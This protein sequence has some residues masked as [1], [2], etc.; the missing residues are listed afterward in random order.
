MMNI[1]NNYDWEQ[2]YGNEHIMQHQ[3]ENESLS[4][5]GNNSNDENNRCGESA[6][7]D[8]WPHA[9]ELSQTLPPR[10]HSFMNN[11]ANLESLQSY[12]DTADTGAQVTQS[13]EWDCE[14]LKEVQSSAKRLKTHVNE[15]PHDRLMHTSSHVLHTTLDSGQVA[16]NESAT[17]SATIRPLI[18][19]M[20]HPQLNYS[21]HTRSRTTFEPHPHQLQH[22]AYEGFNDYPVL[23]NHSPRYLGVNS[24][25]PHQQSHHRLLFRN[26]TNR[27]HH[28][29]PK[30]TKGSAS[31]V[32]QA[33]QQ[34]SSSNRYARQKQPQSPEFSTLESY[35]SYHHDFFSNK[36][37]CLD[38]ATDIPYSHD[39]HQ[40]EPLVRFDFPPPT[41]SQ[42]QQFS[43]QIE[44]S[45][46]AVQKRDTVSKTIAKSL[47]LQYSD[48]IRYQVCLFIVCYISTS[49][50]IL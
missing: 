47:P 15:M 11:T 18:H 1:Q 10:E 2:S 8:L 35:Y 14:M 44:T 7:T 24:N 42:L 39:M 46:S 31:F 19:N 4:E 9:T 38:G 50:C 36:Q 43:H 5:D 34:A 17:T 37:V 20:P 26:Y 22:A 48:N 23:S 27:H 28:Q 30:Q 33:H 16:Q 40:H 3:D 45:M 32:P 13:R 25:W 49:E 21:N 6:Q 12:V 29:N 41:P